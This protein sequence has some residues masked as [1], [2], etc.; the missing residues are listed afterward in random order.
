MGGLQLVS[1]LVQFLEDSSVLK[2][3][4]PQAARE[5]LRQACA[6][7]PV[8]KLLLGW[9]IPRTL[10]DAVAE[11]AS[12]LSV[13]LYRWQPL[14]TGD[15]TIFTPLEWQVV[16]VNGESVPGFRGLPEFTFMCPSK[17]AVQE[18]VSRRLRD[19]SIYPYQGVFLDRIRF[20]SPTGQ[21]FLHLAC[22]CEDCCRVAKEVDHLDLA[23]LRKILCAFFQTAEA[24]SFLSASLLGNYPPELPSEI[25]EGLQC[26][27]RFRMKSI[28]NF[29]RLAAETASARGME[30][31]LDCFSPSLT[32]MVGQDL[33]SLSQVS[34]WIK[35]MTYAHAWGPAGLAYEFMGLT[36]FLC[37]KTGMSKADALSFLRKQSQLGLPGSIQEL[38]T[39]GLPS[40]ALALEVERG[41][42]LGLHPLYAGLELVEI[43]GVC[44]L[45]PGKIRR[46]WS[47]VLEA[48]I[49]GVVLSWDLWHMPLDRLRLV[50]DILVKYS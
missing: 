33:P 23:E 41:R 11:E 32:G 37:Q 21:P 10:F 7:F 16:G 44:E 42:T 27:F 15:G 43:V 31:G 40:S 19:I 48:G 5:C 46:D 20:P 36:A 26:F 13:M 50:S 14:L 17:P 38:R 25:A 47:A 18:A 45:S 24:A 28:S 12:Q 6:L 34:D 30:I 39:R 4:T 2:E 29:V 1:I 9:N 8:S 35:V 3:I 22:F 49:E